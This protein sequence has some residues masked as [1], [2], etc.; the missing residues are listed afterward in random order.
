MSSS[1]TREQPGQGLLPSSFIESEISQVDKHVPHN[2]SRLER[3]IQDMVH[4]ED[5]GGGISLAEFYGRLTLP[6][7][8]I[9]CTCMAP[10]M[11]LYLSH[12]FPFPYAGGYRLPR[13]FPPL[14]HR[15]QSE[16]A[17]L[18]S[19]IC[20]E[21]LEYATFVFGEL[22]ERI[23]DPFCCPPAP[24]LVLAI[25][26]SQLS[27]YNLIH[28]SRAFYMLSIPSLYHTILIGDSVSWK[29][30]VNCLAINKGRACNQPDTP[31]N[32]SFIKSIHFLAVGTLK[33]GPICEP[34]DLPNLTICRSASPIVFAYRSATLDPFFNAPRLRT[35]E[36]GFANPR[37]CLH[38]AAIFPSLT[39]C[40][41]KTLCN[42]HPLRSPPYD[43]I[44][45]RLEATMVGM[46]WP[47]HR[48]LRLDLSR[49]SA[50]KM[51]VN[52]PFI[53]SLYTIGHQIRFLDIAT[54]HLDNPHSATSIN[55]SELPALVTLIIDIS[56]PGYKWHLLDG[57]THSSL[58]RVGFI[59]PSKQQRYTVY[60][61]HFHKFDRHRFP[62]LE[63]IRMLEMPV[64]HR[65]VTQN[66]Q[67]VVNWSDELGSRGV[68]LEAA[69]G[70]RLA[71]LLAAVVRPP[72]NHRNLTHFA[73]LDSGV[74]SQTK[75][76]K[77]GSQS[78]SEDEERWCCC[79]EGTTASK[80]VECEASFE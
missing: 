24:E 43:A 74:R 7:S 73:P 45:L 23:Y 66:P 67:R 72:A 55:L 61:D 19:E 60:R 21:I 65:L 3:F 22:E 49:L 27:R 56:M 30:L 15:R 68:R 54:S 80:T 75:G 8:L 9:C 78:K 4:S 11:S 39:S 70:T 76:H 52:T 10:V 28:V 17:Q 41:A 63:Q 18:P 46:E 59:V 77:W 25:K 35:L 48:D 44:S 37:S 20:H 57:H 40:F 38:T 31:F 5:I 32:T 1:T 53:S 26:A 42:M 71:C 2:V 6:P 51:A 50:I 58:K 47:F 69:D 14:R 13:F 29:R 36:G 34:I 12:P 62:A 16:M 64:C 79:Y 33:W